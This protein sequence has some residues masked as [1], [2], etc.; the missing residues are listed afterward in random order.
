LKQIEDSNEFTSFQHA[1]ACWKL[2]NT[3]AE[4]STVEN[5]Q[6]LFDL[7]ISKNYIGVSNVLLGPLIKV[8]IINNDMKGA[9]EKFEFCCKTYRCTPWKNELALK[10]IEAEDA[11]SLQILTDLSTTIHGE[12]N[13][14]YDLMFAFIECGRVKQARKILE[15][16]G[17]RTRQDRINA[18]CAKYG[19]DENEGALIRL[20]E[21]T[22]DIGM[23][24][25]SR[26]FNELLQLYS[27]NNKVEE[28]M[29][30]WTQMQEEDTQPSE[31]FM[32]SLSELLKKNNLEVPFTVKK[33]KDD[34]SNVPSNVNNNLSTQLN[35]CLKNNNLTKALTLHKMLRSKNVFVNPTD[36]SKII[37][38]LTR[39]N[40][41][42]EAVEIAKDMLKN[43]RP[44]TKHIL[45]FLIKN[46]SESGDVANLEYLNEKISKAMSN[47]LNMNSKIFNAYQFQG[48][49]N[50]LLVRLEATID[51][52]IN[53]TTKLSEIIQNIPGGNLVN[54]LKSDP[55]IK[56]TIERLHSK[57][58][59]HG[60][61]V[62]A[63]SLWSYFM[64][65]KQFDNATNIVKELENSKFV[66]YRQL[67]TDIR[68]NNN[69]E[70]GNKLLEIIPQFKEINHNANIGLVYSALI[71]AYVHNGD[72]NKASKVLDEAL[73]KVKLHDIN[74]S[75]VL[76]LKK[77]LEAQG[78]TLK[79]DT[80]NLKKRISTKI[81]KYT[82]MTPLLILTMKK[83]R[84][85]KIIFFFKFIL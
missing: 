69:I 37:E 46:L 27:K 8:H 22:K 7:I 44:I 21:V 43:G 66:Q 16:P 25:R 76:R 73:E 79:Y 54:A 18:A 32:W 62:F 24:D 19:S 35:L 63:N 20:I 30:L 60:Y 15:T 5:V 50:D 80:N 41:H 78:Q 71:D 51:E 45:S 13:S 12:V 33:P 82:V 9:L 55:S 17:L 2:L 58:S 72:I 85:T 83:L 48:N 64:L 14:L 61:I 4:S 68:T 10:F 1:N 77:S 6:K 47:K 28:A 53:D 11:I 3:V 56:P 23:F 57:V 26:I 31:H 49:I 65:N 39:E 59:A 81:Q 67:L 52:N 70:L 29:A 36:E 84:K 74:E 38:L 40:K 75:A 42:N 34:A